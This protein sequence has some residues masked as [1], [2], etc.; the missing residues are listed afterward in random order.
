MKKIVE[1]VEGEG[2]VK[3]MGEHVLIWCM[4]YNYSGRLIGVNDQDII[5]EDAHVVYETGELNTTGF[6]DA[7]KL[8][9][10]EG[11]YIRTASIESYGVWPK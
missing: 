1:D 10:A 5:L 8:P 2:L 3:L 11:H 9:N 4:N 6:K 7:Q